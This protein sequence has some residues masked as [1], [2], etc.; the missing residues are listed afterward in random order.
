M[1]YEQF[2]TTG[3]K[4]HGI[5]ALIRV[6]IRPDAHKGG[7]AKVRRTSTRNSR[8]RVPKTADSSSSSKST[9]FVS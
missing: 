5:C 2:A 1:L 4:G 9:N 7:L 3:V 6:R 8:P